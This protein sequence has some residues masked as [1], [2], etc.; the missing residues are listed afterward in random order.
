MPISKIGW[1]KNP[2]LDCKKPK[3]TEERNKDLEERNMEINLVDKEDI[4]VKH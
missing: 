1:K 2:C 4:K 3:E